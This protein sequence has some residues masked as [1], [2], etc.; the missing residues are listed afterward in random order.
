MSEPGTMYRTLAD[1][2]ARLAAAQA[3]RDAAVERAERAEIRLR[4]V[5]DHLQCIRPAVSQIFKGGAYARQDGVLQIVEWT[6]AAIRAAA[7]AQ[8]E[9]PSDAE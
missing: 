2:R 7:P 9:E 4:A 3:E 8:P 5:G 1:L 6:D